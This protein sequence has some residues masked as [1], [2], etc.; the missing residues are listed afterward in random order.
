MES[1]NT[2]KGAK[3][4]VLCAPIRLTPCTCTQLAVLYKERAQLAVLYKERADD[5]D[6]AEPVGVPIPVPVPVAEDRSRRTASASKILLIVA[7]R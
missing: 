6:Q 5:Q 3:L 2:S 4:R 7:R 1:R